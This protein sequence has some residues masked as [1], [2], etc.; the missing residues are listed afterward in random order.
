ML[1]LRSSKM[2]N[3]DSEH[4]DNEHESHY[5]VEGGSY[6]GARLLVLP[7]ESELDY[8]LLHTRLA[9]ELA[10]EGVLEEDA[11][12]TIAK[13]IRRK[14]RLQELLKAR[15]MVASFDPDHQLFDEQR[16]LSA[17]L[18]I[19]DHETDVPELERWLLVLLGKGLA[20]ELER[21]CARRKFAT[22]KRWIKALRSEAFK[23][24]G[25]ACRFGPPADEALINQSAAFLTDEVFARELE[26]E[27]RIDAELDKALKRLFAIR[28][29]KR[30]ISFRARERFDRS[31]PVTL[32]GIRRKVRRVDPVGEKPTKF[33]RA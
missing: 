31:H 28:A 24:Y 13:C 14:Q 12:S 20:E 7:G 25:R 6:L 30:Q 32:A 18:Q 16:A 29:A 3:D 22:P 21:K 26:F 17:F 4:K 33:D 2:E 15:L 11:V 19:L 1:F 9:E 5:E 8:E 27:A 23:L 10:P